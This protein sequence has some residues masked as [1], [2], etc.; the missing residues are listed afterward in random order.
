MVKSDS[1]V[2][3]APSPSD[4]KQPYYAREEPNTL[5]RLE[6]TKAESI[7]WC[8]AVVLCG[9]TAQVSESATH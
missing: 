1:A 3:E 2:A 9:E 5:L 4:A 7:G 8:A 6:S